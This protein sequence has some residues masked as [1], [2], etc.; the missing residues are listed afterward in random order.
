MSNGLSMSA[1]GRAGARAG[2]RGEAAARVTAAS[3]QS[4]SATTLSELLAFLEKRGD[5]RFE[6]CPAFDGSGLDPELKE[7]D[8]AELDPGDPDA[9]DFDESDDE[10]LIEDAVKFRILVRKQSGCWRCDVDQSGWEGVIGETPFGKRVVHAVTKRTEAY[11]AVAAWLEKDFAGQ[12][13]KGPFAFSR[14]LAQGCL[15]SQ[16]EFCA[17]RKIRQS[18]F[19]RYLKNAVLSWREGSIPLRA[20]FSR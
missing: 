3:V 17:P 4:V 9:R 20:L 13:A 6:D 14:F 11:C 15:P 7:D 10:W 5:V 16:A 19:S 8:L 1:V 18:A 12:L 2:A